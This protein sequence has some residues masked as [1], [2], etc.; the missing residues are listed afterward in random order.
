MRKSVY[1]GITGDIISPG[2]INIVN[3]GARL[4]E[5]TVGL[6][7]DRAI[8]S[9]KRIPYLSFEQ[10]KMVVEGLKGMGRGVPQDDWSYVPN[11]RRYKPDI[12]I[13]GDDWKSNYLSKERED[14]FRVVNEWG[15]KIVEVPYTRGH[16]L[17]RLGR[18][19]L[20]N[21]HHS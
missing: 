9:H 16:Q 7:T 12:M 2:I 11:L 18:K 3:E 4:G 5:L 20:H 8:V 19:C 1:L 14:C 13:H 10:R 6:L 17:N 21:R 15:G